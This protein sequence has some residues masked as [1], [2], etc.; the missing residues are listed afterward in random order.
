MPSK[1]KLASAIDLNSEMV[2]SVMIPNEQP[3]Q[4]DVKPKIEIVKFGW[5]IGVLVCLV[6][7]KN[8]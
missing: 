4:T 3:L 1:F 5:I 2:S 7:S 6:F 8:Y